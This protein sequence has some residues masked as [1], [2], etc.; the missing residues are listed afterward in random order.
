[1]NRVAVIDEVMNSLR[2]EGLEIV[3]VEDKSNRDTLRISYKVRLK[4]PLK[5]IPITFQLGSTMGAIN[6]SPYMWGI[7][8]TTSPG[9]GAQIP[10]PACDDFIEVVFDPASDPADWVQEKPGSDVDPDIVYYF[11]GLVRHKFPFDASKRVNIGHSPADIA[12]FIRA[13]W[14]HGLTLQPP[15][16][17]RGF[18]GRAVFSSMT[19]AVDVKRRISELQS[20]VVTKAVDPDVTPPA[21]YC[22]N[23]PDPDEVAIPVAHPIDYATQALAS[24]ATCYVCTR[25]QTSRRSSVGI[26]VCDKCSK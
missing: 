11:R 18:N 23:L 15:L 12:D 13:E 24:M 5:M 8:G 14:A 22:I 17:R 10:P 16:I 4:Q 21:P 19:P 1:M 2:A 9:G 20:G 7:P 3:D 25:V 6:V 26:P